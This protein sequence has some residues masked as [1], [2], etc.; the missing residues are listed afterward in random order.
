MLTSRDYNIFN[1]IDR[2]SG[3]TISQAG[4]VFFGNSKFSYDGARKRLRKLTDN[5]FL[6]YEEDFVTNKRIYYRKKKGS[7]HGMLLADFY[8]NLIAEGAAVIEFEKELQLDGCRPDGFVVFQYKKISKMCFIEIDMQHKTNLDKYVKIYESGYFQKKYGTFPV[9][10]IVTCHKPESYKQ[11]K[12]PFKYVFLN[13]N[14][15]EMEEKLL[16]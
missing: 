9:I 6:K 11:K 16:V 10:A 5:G 13:Y 8:A 4:M 7:S 14:F 15:M 1:F 3:I 2:F 12:Y